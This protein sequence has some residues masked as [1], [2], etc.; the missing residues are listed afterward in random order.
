MRITCLL[1]ISGLILGACSSEPPQVQAP[2]DTKAVEAYQ[3]KVY[4]GNTATQAE[5]ELAKR[6]VNMPLNASD[7]N[8][9]Y[10]STVQ[11]R[12]VVPVV[13]WWWR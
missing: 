2:L 13:G 4:S 1:L 11:P 9:T 3:T 8:P 10:N 6:P 12:V 5:K 7:S